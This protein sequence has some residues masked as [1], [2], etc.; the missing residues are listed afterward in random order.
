MLLFFD[1]STALNYLE[2][3]KKIGYSSFNEYLKVRGFDPDQ[4]S[5]KTKKTIMILEHGAWI[6]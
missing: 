3:N 2:P 6:S 1:I 5:L 4:L